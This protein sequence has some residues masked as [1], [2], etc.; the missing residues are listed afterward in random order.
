[1]ETHGDLKGLTSN[2]L[3][4]MRT[5]MAADRTLMAWV[6]TA[7]GMISFGFS[8]YKFIHALEPGRAEAP[9]H[10]GIILTLMG[11]LSLMAGT[12]EYVRTLGALGGRRLGFPFYFACAVILVG[13]AV[14]A[15]IALRVGPLS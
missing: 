8:I 1:M 10:F 3:A 9:R 14:F 2:D 7:L 11:T 4:A 6:R 15:G 13:M 5:S 12:M